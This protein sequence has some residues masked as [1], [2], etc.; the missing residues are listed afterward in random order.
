MQNVVGR[1]S[2]EGKVELLG[3]V[4]EIGARENGQ[5]EKLKIVGI[6]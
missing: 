6:K 3:A 1:I 5:A 2:V 4:V